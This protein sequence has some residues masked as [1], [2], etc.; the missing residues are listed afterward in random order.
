MNCHFFIMGLQVRLVSFLQSVVRSP[1]R[2]CHV[3]YA[4]STHAGQSEDSRNQHLPVHVATQQ[5]LLKRR[6]LRPPARLHAW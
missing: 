5:R 6:A 2:W 1:V 4:R 3:V